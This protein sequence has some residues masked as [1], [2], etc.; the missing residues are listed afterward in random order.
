MKDEPLG[1][2][3]AL[4]GGYSQDENYTEVEQGKKPLP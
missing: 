1:L 3:F 2:F 4:T